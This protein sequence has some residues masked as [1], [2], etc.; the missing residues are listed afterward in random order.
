MTS[1]VSS[2]EGA[3]VVLVDGDSVLFVGASVDSDDGGGVV[4]FGL[5]PL[6]AERRPH[7]IATASNNEILESIV[8]FITNSFCKRENIFFVLINQLYHIK[9]HISI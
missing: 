3:S 6:H 9:I 7:S 2:E 4:T 8:L 1:S 5:L